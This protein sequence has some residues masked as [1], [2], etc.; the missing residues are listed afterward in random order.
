MSIS[1]LHFTED[2]L[3]LG[4]VFT[5]WRFQKEYVVQSIASYTKQFKSLPALSSI[6][7][8]EALRG[9]EKTAVSGQYSQST[10]LA[11]QNTK[12]LIDLCTVLPFDQEAAVIAAQI[13]ARVNNKKIWADV[14]IAAT[15]ISHRH[16]VATRNRGDFE[17]IAKHGPEDYPRLRLVFWNP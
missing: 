6:T 14:F 1:S 11:L 3:L 9:F 16:G 17:L 5:A 4:D 8:F 13:F 2:L 7:V 12:N 15:A 10:K